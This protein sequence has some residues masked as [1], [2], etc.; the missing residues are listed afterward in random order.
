MWS[1]TFNSNEILAPS[2]A[3]FS[4]KTR[5]VCWCSNRS[6]VSL[7]KEYKH[8]GMISKIWD[9]RRDFHS[10]LFLTR[11]SQRIKSWTLSRNWGLAYCKAIGKADW[12]SKLKSQWFLLIRVWL[13]MTL[14]RIQ[15]YR[16][17]VGGGVNCS[18]KTYRTNTND[19]QK[20]I[21]H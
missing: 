8:M 19:I 6:I 1:T 18:L 12:Y 7:A 5:C 16:L 9:R 21:K 20:F 11:G 3:C 14:V 15:S 4:R 10:H 2:W 17:E 13:D